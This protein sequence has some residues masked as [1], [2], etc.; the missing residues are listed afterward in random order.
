MESWSRLWQNETG[1]RT[2]AK[3]KVGVHSGKNGKLE[4]TLLGRPDFIIRSEDIP[5]VSNRLQWF[6]DTLLLGI[7]PR[8]WEDEIAS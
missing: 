1:L 4:S 5:L 7:S 6:R 8:G 3:W 2:L